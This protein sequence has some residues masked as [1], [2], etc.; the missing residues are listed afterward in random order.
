LSDIQ[1]ICS[2]DDSKGAEN[3]RVENAGMENARIS[4][5]VKHAQCA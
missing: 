2:A 5:Y 3:A 4:K 1:A